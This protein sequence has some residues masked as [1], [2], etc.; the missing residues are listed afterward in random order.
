MSLI[1]LDNEPIVFDLSPNGNT[2]RVMAHWRD[3]KR[4]LEQTKGLN[5]TPPTASSNS[6][7]GVGSPNSLPKSSNTLSKSSGPSIQDLQSQIPSADSGSDFEKMMS[8]SSV[9]SKIYGEL[10]PSG[11]WIEAEKLYNEV[12]S[13]EVGSQTT[14]LMSNFGIVLYLQ[15]RVDEGIGQFNRVL[16]RKDRFA[17]AEASWFLTRIYRERGEQT[18]ADLYTD[19]CRKSG[20][21]STPDFLVD[22][23]DIKGD[24]P[25]FVRVIDSI[26]GRDLRSF[27][28]FLT[29]SE[30]EFG[31]QFVG[32]TFITQSMMGI[33]GREFHTCRSCQVNQFPDG[34]SIDPE[35]MAS[36]NRIN[37]GYSCDQCGRNPSNY[38]PIRPGSGISLVTNADLYCNGSCIGTISITNVDFFEQMVNA[39][40]SNSSSEASPLHEQTF[41]NFFNARA[42]D[43]IKN[44][45]GNG[46]PI[47]WGTIE[48]VIEKRWSKDENPFSGFFF[49]EHGEG[50]DSETGVD[51][52]KNTRPGKF[53][54][55]AYCGVGD[56]GDCVPLLILTLRKQFV[57]DSGLFSVK[58]SQFEMQNIYDIWK[59]KAKQIASSR[60]VQAYSA[61]SNAL[62]F[63]SWAENTGMGDAFKNDFKWLALSWISLVEILDANIPKHEG[64]PAELVHSL[65]L[66]GLYS[67]A[68]SIGL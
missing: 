14:N 5:S 43:Y 30:N 57:E 37:P 51:Y 3:F 12:I 29:Q 58:L 60:E 46:E 16:N 62:I 55:L 42:L 66:R 48:N 61:R 31:I 45:P 44:L 27:I 24:N 10:I 67:R 38:I 64:P 6:L 68:N 49:G 28:Q 47:Y 7:S 19:K 22:G 32:S 40:S 13:L 15:G 20:G 21:Y 54:V 39:L 11:N 50:V 8:V 56:Q 41:E 9:N 33:A 35:L 1:R 17:E 52:S 53:D 4:K 36:W 65:R 63:G 18:L 59:N 25:Y 26:R 23:T 2:R 34:G